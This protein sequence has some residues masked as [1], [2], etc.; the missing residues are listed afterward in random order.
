M[1][2][3]TPIDKKYRYSFV[4][5][6]HNDKLTKE[7]THSGWYN[8]KLL[9]ISIFLL[10]KYICFSCHYRVYL[11]CFLTLSYIASNTDPI[12]PRINE[13]LHIKPWVVCMY[14]GV[15]LLK[16][17]DARCVITLCHCANKFYV[18]SHHK[19]IIIFCHNTYIIPVGPEHNYCHYMN[20]LNTFSH[21]LKGA[22]VDLFILLNRFTWDKSVSFYHRAICKRVCHDGNLKKFIVHRCLY[23]K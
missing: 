1:T 5:F 8:C 13:H 19:S 14:A 23:L 16:L 3:Q 22:F 10:Q 4:W 6:T 12:T 20:V 18:F 7:S 15:S 9:Y 21:S 17:I 2:G 11:Y